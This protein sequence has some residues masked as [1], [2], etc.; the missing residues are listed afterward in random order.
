MSS[1]TRGSLALDCDPTED[2]LWRT[3]P[4]DHSI[5]GLRAEPE[6]EA[7][8]EPVSFFAR[9]LERTLAFR[10]PELSQEDRQIAVGLI[11][12]SVE[13]EVGPLLSAWRLW[14]TSQLDMGNSLAMSLHP[15]GVSAL[16]GLT[17]SSPWFM[18]Q[19]LRGELSSLAARPWLGAA[20][21]ALAFVIGLFGPFDI[22]TRAV[23]V[24]AALLA[25][26]K[27]IPL[28]PSRLFRH[29]LR[30]FVSVVFS[31]PFIVAGTNGVVTP[32]VGRLLP[33]IEPYV[34][35]AIMAGSVAVLLTD[36]TN[37]VGS[38]GQVRVRGMGKRFAGWL[39]SL[40][41]KIR[42]HW[43]GPNDGT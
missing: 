9:V 4:G 41:D 14:L 19:E 24:G 15:K 18:V 10:Q 11:R 37:V 38:W 27:V 3:Y 12:S 6:G 33:G 42:S 25:L 30:D 26:A 32:L 29:R 28:G 39:Q 34:R 17:I 31:Y 20:I 13:I 7:W 40:A 5:P 43:N 22:L 1:G 23:L 8:P 21:T 16:A 2:I 36:L 35:V